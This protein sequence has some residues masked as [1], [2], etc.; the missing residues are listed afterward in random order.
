[1]GDASTQFDSEAFDF[2]GMNNDASSAWSS[3]SR[4]RAN[5]ATANGNRHGVFHV[6]ALDIEPLEFVP[7]QWIN[8]GD[9]L[10]GK[11]YVGAMKSQVETRANKAAD[12]RGNYASEQTCC[13]EGFNYHA[14]KEEVHNPSSNHAGSRPELFTTTHSS[15]LTQGVTN[16]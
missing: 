10:V 16:V 5:D 9:A 15:I 13:G 12:Q 8:D 4:P 1:M 11:E 14:Q 2:V 6:D 7:A 3:W